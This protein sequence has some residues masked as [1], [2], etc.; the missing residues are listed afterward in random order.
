MVVNDFL[1]INLSLNLF[2]LEKMNF[3]LSKYKNTQDDAIN[4]M[5]VKCLIL[6]IIFIG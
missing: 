6:K 2:C 4:I 5:I 3:K 1:Y